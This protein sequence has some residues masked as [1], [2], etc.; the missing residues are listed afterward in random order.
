MLFLFF[1]FFLLK[2]DYTLVLKLWSRAVPKKNRLGVR[3]MGIK[4]ILSI[5]DRRKT[6]CSLVFPPRT[7]K[8][9]TQKQYSDTFTLHT[10]TK[11]KFPVLILP[12]L[13]MDN[14]ALQGHGHKHNTMQLQP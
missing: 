6:D 13:D 8:T 7:T 5:F 1:Y 10:T 3:F 9:K 12:K 14:L 2:S 4:I 11:G